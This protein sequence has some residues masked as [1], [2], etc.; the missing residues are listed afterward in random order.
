MELAKRELSKRK[1]LDFILYRFEEYKPNWH[2]KK[3]IEKLEAVERGEIKRLIVTMPPRHGKS[4]IISVNFPAWFIGRNPDKSII[5]ASYSSDLASDFGGQTR[6]VIASREYSNVF[7]KIELAEDSKAKNNWKIKNKRGRYVATGVGGSITGKGA[8]VFVI[9][10]PIKNREDADSPV[11]REKIWKWYISTARTRLSKDGAIIVVHTRWHDDDL[12]GRLLK[13][14]N[15]DSWEIVNFPAIAIE[16]EEQRVVGEALWEEFFPLENLNDTKREI[17][18]YEWSALYQQNPVDEDSQEFKT[19]WFRYRTLEEVLSRPSRKFAS[20]DTALSRGAKSDFT[21]VTRNYVNSDNEW[22]VRSERYK[23]SSKDLVDLIFLLHSESFEVIGIEEGAYL[24][25]VE[26][27]LKDE[28]VKRNKFPNVV[29]LKHGG[30]MKETRI[31]GLIPRYETGSVFHIDKSC[32]DLEE[33][34]LRFPKG[35]H[36]DCADSLAYQLN[37]AQPYISEDEDFSLY[38]SSFT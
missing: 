5:T 19:A 16:N 25:A 32:V 7:D 17:G 23:I 38:N 3:L 34:L 36:D 20:I 4:E 14:E 21:G 11:I 26:P 27:F 8:D 15:K 31:R 18:S 35:T 10:D 1:L 30:V 13:S 12:I 29:V 37:I 33:E 6:D 2:H 9:D 24:S 22:N 28:M